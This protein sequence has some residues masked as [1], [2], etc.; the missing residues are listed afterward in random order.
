MRPLL[1][2]DLMTENVFTLGRRDDLA[3]LY[4]LK[5]GEHIRHI[6]VVDEAGRVVG[7]VTHRELL[8]AAL[9]SEPDHPLLLQREV[10]E[11]RT[12]GEIMLTAVETIG[13]DRP[14]GDAAQIMLDNRIGCLPVAQGGKLVG[15]LTEADLVKCLV[16]M[17]PGVHVTLRAGGQP[18]PGKGRKGGAEE[19]MPRDVRRKAG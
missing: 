13:P 7:L 11:G 5:D 18:P 2:R 1:V 19:P 8:R 10:L 4:D 16:G 14:V 15:I 6:P 17:I 12:V 9:G 3:V